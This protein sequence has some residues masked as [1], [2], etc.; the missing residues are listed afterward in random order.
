MLGRIQMQ[1]KNYLQMLDS[2]DLKHVSECL[3]SS[4]TWQKGFQSQSRLVLGFI[5]QWTSSE[6]IY[7][8]YHQLVF[9][10]KLLEH[11]S[12]FRI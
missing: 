8:Y 1:K 11:I 10:R 6:N 7:Q 5:H 9:I 4:P 2:K 3:D 12:V